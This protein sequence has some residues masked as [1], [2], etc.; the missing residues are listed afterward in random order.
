MFMPV[1]QKSLHI[2][3]EKKTLILASPRGFCAGVDRAIE[4]VE[5]SLERFS[6]PLYVNH[7]IVHNTHVVEDL[8]KKGVIFTEDMDSIPKG[9]TVIFSA[10]G[11]PPSLWEKAQARDLQII[12]AT[13]PLVTKVHLGVRRYAKKDYTIIYIGH[14]N[15]AET[16]GTIGE[17]PEHIVIVETLS[18]VASLSFSKDRKLVYLTQT[19][20]SFSE[21]KEIIQKLKEKFPQIEGPTRDDICYATTNRQLAVA[22]IAPYVSLMLVIGSQ[23]SSNSN[24]LREVAERHGVTSYLIDDASHIQQEWIIEDIHA[25]GITAGA[26]AP[27]VLLEQVIERLQKEFSFTE[28]VHYQEIQEHVSFQLPKILK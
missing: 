5:R 17:A 22:A 1:T 11:V 23:N 25:I 28:L 16:I 3:K 6:H 12:D 13:C 7:E 27:E 9:E 18:D 20:L 15:H 19:T 14:K 2:S 4:I 26:S 8:K 21:T 24:R 10:H